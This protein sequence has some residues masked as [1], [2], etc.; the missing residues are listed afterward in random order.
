MKHTHVVM[1]SGGVGSWAAAK[2]VAERHGTEN[3][4]LLFADTLM[5]DEDLYRFLDEAAEDVGGR[6]V[7]VAD[8][9]NPWD[10]FNDVRFLGNTRVDPCSKILK[11]E[12]LDKWLDA[13]CDRDHTTVH[14]GISWDEE[15]R[16]VRAK[17][18][19][20]SKGW[21]CSAPLCEEPLPPMGSEW[22]LEELDKAGIA[23]PRL[24]AMGFKHNNCGGF[25][26][27]AGQAHFE[28]LLRVM[29]ERYAYHEEQE[30]DIRMTLGDVAI[31]R[32]RRG[33]TTK[34][35]TLRAFR[36]R[37]EAKHGFDENE[38][39]GCGCFSG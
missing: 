18:R 6:L 7:K 38:W 21:T 9:R 29:P 35:M 37:L 13:N 30:Q 36:K 27:K 33:G 11:R 34:P 28:L 15:H 25:C 5:E 24:Y 20:D 16:F 3:L 10:V 17:S 12:L 8:G 32:D 22:A 14:L 4:I 19:F 31:L 39:G 1:F 26:I 2:R 23:R